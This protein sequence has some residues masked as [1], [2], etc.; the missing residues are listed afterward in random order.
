MREDADIHAF[1]GVNEPVDGIRRP[2]FP[3]R[4]ARVADVKLRDALFAREADD[5]V[6]RIPYSARGVSAFEDVRFGAEFASVIEIGLNDFV[7]LAREAF[8]LY[9]DSEQLSMEPR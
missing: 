2:E 8:L 7:G 1:G 6:D 4:L 5:D 3:G 9:P